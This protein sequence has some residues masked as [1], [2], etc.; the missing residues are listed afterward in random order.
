MLYMLIERYKNEDP[1]LRE[2]DVVGIYKTREAATAE[3]KAIIEEGR[4]GMERYN[5]FISYHRCQSCAKRTNECRKCFYEFIEHK[6]GYAIID[7]ELFDE[8]K[9]CIKE[10]RLNQRID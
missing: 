8:H 3:V 6:N 9:Y 4:L 2:D 7:G 10:V 5:K 1:D